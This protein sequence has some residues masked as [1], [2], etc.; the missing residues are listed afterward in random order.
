MCYIN[1]LRI[2]LTEY[3]KFKGIEK[4]LNEIHITD[5]PAHKGFDYGKWPVIKP[6]VDGKDWDIENMEWGFLPSYLEN[7]EAVHK[8]RYGYKDES[9]KFHKA[10]T[11][12]NAMGEEIIKPGKMFR[13]AGL[14][15]RCLV[16][17]SEFYEHRHV[18][19]LNKRTGVPLKTAL[20][21]PYRITIPSMPIFMMAAIYQPWTDKETG[22][23]KDTFAI[24]TTKANSLME[25]VHNTKMRM[26]VIFT[27]ALADEWT[28]PDLSE[29]RISELACF[30][31][32]AKLMEAHTVKKSFLE[33]ID[34]NKL[35]SYPDLA[36]LNT[37]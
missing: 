20:K 7:E 5:R 23:T 2:S 1:G 3:I 8:F 27:E 9:G 11:T 21:Y 32:K 25:Q 12:L 16:L 36:A 34:P 19:P 15:R 30:Q 35:F 28:N 24:V 4:E 13:E 37:K 33:E 26:P 31:F 22:E 17:S 10:L 18:F 29:Q 6:S 14:R